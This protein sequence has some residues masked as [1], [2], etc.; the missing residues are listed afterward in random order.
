MRTVLVVTALLVIGMH[1]VA[2]AE[3]SFKPV[4][5][6]EPGRDALASAFALFLVVML[7]LGIWD[8]FRDKK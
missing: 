2:Y 7:G 6:Y 8:G 4:P 3:L 1:S 5:R